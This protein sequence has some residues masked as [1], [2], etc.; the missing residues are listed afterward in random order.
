VIDRLKESCDSATARASRRAL[1]RELKFTV[2]ER[3]VAA[4]ARRPFVV[5]LSRSTWGPARLGPRPTGCVPIASRNLAG[6]PE[7]FALIDLEVARVNEDLPRAAQIQA[8]RL[9]STKELE[10]ATTS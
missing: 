6:K 7:V 8:F 9:C 3:G 5:A 10:P 2:R 1:N 4:W